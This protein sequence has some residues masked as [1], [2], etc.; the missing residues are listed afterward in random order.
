MAF[1]SLYEDSHTLRR[2][3]FP[4]QGGL[5]QECSLTAPDSSSQSRGIQCS[6]LFSL[7]EVDPCVLYPESSSLPRAYLQSQVSPLISMLVTSFGKYG[8]NNNYFKRFSFLFFFQKCKCLEEGFGTLKLQCIC[9]YYSNCIC[10]R[11][12][13]K[14]T[15][16]QLTFSF[17]SLLSKIQYRESI[18][19]MLLFLFH[20]FFCNFT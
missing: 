5:A 6:G 14:K 13:L 2:K 7:V 12:P 3:S 4:L 20:F 8:Y 18:N 15:K 9:Y 17:F 11:V 16:S 19:Q 10:L 1:F